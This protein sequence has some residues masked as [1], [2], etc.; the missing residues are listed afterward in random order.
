MSNSS[1]P[2]SHIRPPFPLTQTAM[3]TYSRAIAAFQRLQSQTLLQGY[4][5]TGQALEAYLHPNLDNWAGTKPIYEPRS[6]KHYLS[7]SRVLKRYGVKIGHGKWKIESDPSLWGY[8]E[9]TKN[10]V[11]EWREAS[12]K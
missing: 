4:C 6:H 12:T 9:G 10:E 8:S 1:V 7:V 5:T 11:R 2:G 3:P